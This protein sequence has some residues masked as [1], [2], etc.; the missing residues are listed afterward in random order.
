MT[1]PN[2][3]TEPNAD[4]E[5]KSEDVGPS[6]L[7]RRN[8]AFAAIEESRAQTLRDGGLLI[9]ES[10]AS[11]V[12]G[13]GAEPKAEAAEQGA[14]EPDG[15]TPAEQPDAGEADAEAEP[16]AAASTPD[17]PVY[18]VMIDGEERTVPLSEL[19]RNYQLAG[20][21]EGRLNMA[22]DVLRR[23]EDLQGRLSRGESTDD[24]TPADGDGQ[25]GATKANA[26]KGADK[27]PL[28][29]ID[30]E[31]VAQKLQYETPEVGAAALKE[32]VMEVSQRATG[33]GDGP[34]PQ[35]ITQSVMDQVNF[36]TALK[37]FGDDFSDIVEDQYLAQRT[38]ARTN[39]L[40]N[41]AVQAYRTQGA[42]MPSYY[43]LFSRAGEDTRA[44]IKGL[45][46]GEEADPDSE[47]GAESA[48]NP[49]ANTSSAMKD[50]IERKRNLPQP[51]TAR[52]APRKAAKTETS[53]SPPSELER[54]RSGIADIQKARGQVA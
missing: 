48:D 9:D 52:G 21:A 27:D 3:E 49:G 24:A 33:G 2:A 7:D 6:P 44:W 34:S 28:D 12:A 11:E 17:E 23:V 29:G 25:A 19:T 43:D 16:E 10:E 36:Q 26:K 41:D 22:S 4:A 35:E 5:N 47:S 14:A 42:P 53:T 45:G 39:Q 1:K 13:E 32:L 18:K 15:D 20:A 51:P 37:Q 30:F 40:Y 31:S 8:A 54:S 50:R 46:K 38:G